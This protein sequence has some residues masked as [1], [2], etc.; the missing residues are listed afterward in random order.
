MRQGGRKLA[1]I[2]NMLAGKVEVGVSGKQISALAAEEIKKA[3]MQPVVLG[4]Q[5][6]PDVICVSVGEAIVHGVPNNVPFKEGN[7]VKL[8]LTLGYKAMVL[9]SAVTVVVGTQ[10]RPEVK[11]LVKGTKM[12]LEAGINAISG[13]GTRVGDISA[14]VQDVL[15]KHQLG[16][17][18][19]LVGHG[20]GYGIHEEPNVPNYGVAGTGPVLSA[21]MTL[22]IEPMASLGGQYEK[23]R[24]GID[25]RRFDWRAF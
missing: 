8:D 18:R 19:D 6:F 21:G 14:A 12:A 23:G 11:R 20:V 9:D 17:I 13:N 16:V 5:G 22:A 2:L 24:Y 25:A 4:Y 3:G 10:H 15:D 7:V 1:A